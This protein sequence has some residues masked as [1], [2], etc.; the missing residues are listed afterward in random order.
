MCTSLVVSVTSLDMLARVTWVSWEMGASLVLAVAAASMAEAG[1]TE[2]IRSTS[3]IAASSLIGM[4]DSPAFCFFVRLRR[5]AVYKSS[6]V[7][8]ASFIFIQC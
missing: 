5:P 8:I 7:M 4:D 3:L 6:A 2:V 1:W